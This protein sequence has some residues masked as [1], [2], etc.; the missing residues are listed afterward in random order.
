MKA[1]SPTLARVARGNLCAGCGLC[2]AIA[3]PGRIAMGLDPAGYLRPQVRTA[4]TRKEDETIARTCPG[5]T[6]IQTNTEGRRHP[7]WGPIIGCHVGHATDQRLRHH[8][9]SGGALSA[10]LV[11]L[12]E[13]RAVDFV[14]QTAADGERPIANRTVESLTPEDVYRAAGSRYAPS[15]PLADLTA[16]LDRP[17]RFAFV[18]KPCDAA[19]LRAYGREDPR[20][21]EKI[22]CVVSFFCAGVPSLAG[23]QEIVARLGVAERDVVAFHYRGDGWPGWATVTTRE[24]ETRRMSYADSWGGILSNHTQFRCKICPDGSGGFAD[25]VCADAWY[26]DARG[27][28]QFA[29]APGRSLI[30]TRT[31]KGADLLRRATDGGYLV[32]EDLDVGE[33]ER[34]Q[35]GQARRKRLM[36]SRLAALVVL[37]RPRPRFEGLD[38][39]AAARAAGARETV[40][41][42]A[43]M[44]R[45]GW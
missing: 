8:A 25:V 9:A 28:P 34:M 21:A 45:R 17:G 30:L 31:A 43:G 16:R 41:S 15:A 24:G 33:I 26:G 10:L 13:S 19:A 18:G 32:V 37:G 38:L 11:Y 23:A 36:L 44:V 22:A 27:Y 3:A 12:I 5:V 42:F 7:L 39:L 35:P 2:Q 40:R 29:E 14:V 4:L 1:L 20:V 6:L